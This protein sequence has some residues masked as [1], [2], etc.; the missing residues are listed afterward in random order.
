MT[1]LKLEPTSLAS[2]CSLSKRIRNFVHM[3][4]EPSDSSLNIKMSALSSNSSSN[5]V[6]QYFL[7]FKIFGRIWIS[8]LNRARQSLIIVSR[9]GAILKRRVFGFLARLNHNL[10]KVITCVVA[11]DKFPSPEEAFA[12][13]RR[14]LVCQ[15]IMLID[16]IIAPEPPTPEM[17]AYLQQLTHSKCCAIISALDVNIAIDQVTSRMN[18]G[19]S[20]E[21]G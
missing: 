8:S 15:K 4:Q 5:S 12:E 14:E 11:Q 20:R 2:T 13:A 19:N 18:V 3:V 21:T 9:V 10:D 7:I 16:E 6:S 1:T 17:S